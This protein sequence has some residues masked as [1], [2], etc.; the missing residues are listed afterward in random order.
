MSLL[1]NIFILLLT[2]ILWWVQRIF[3]F[4]QSIGEIK[5]EIILSFGKYFSSFDTNNLNQCSELDYFDALIN[6]LNLKS[7]DF[8][9]FE[10]NNLLLFISFFIIVLF[11]SVT[12]K[13]SLFQVIKN[14]I[15][16]FIIMLITIL[17]F[18]FIKGAFNCHLHV[19]PRFLLMSYLPIQF[20]IKFNQENK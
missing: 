3:Y 9:Y 17:W 1:F 8:I 7:L 18:M 19:Y 5:K 11:F 4:N 6:F 2:E 15:H 13:Q 16:I 10:I 20:S 12:K 14:N